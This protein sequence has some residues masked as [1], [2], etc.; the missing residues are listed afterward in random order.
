MGLAMFGRK[1]RAFG[2]DYSLYASFFQMKA[3]CTGGE[4]FIDDV[5]KSFGYLDHILY[6]LRGDK[7]DRVSNIGKGKFRW[8]ATRG[9]LKL[10]ILF[11]VEPGDGRDMNRSDRCN[12][13]S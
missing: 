5:G 7:I 1:K 2:L 12:R 10:R 4:R 13:V 3:D 6:L 11:G 9:L 8:A